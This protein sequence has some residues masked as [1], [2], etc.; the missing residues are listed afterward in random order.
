M[1]NDASKSIDK[2]VTEIKLQQTLHGLMY[3]L[4]YPSILGAGIVVVLQ[5]A[6]EHSAAVFVGLTA[7]AFFSLSFASAIGR[8]NEYNILAFVVDVVEVLVM[9]ACF[10]FLKLIEGPPWLPPS[11][12]LA[13]LVLIGVLFLQLGWRWAMHFKVWGYADLKIALVLCLVLG[14]YLGNS[15]EN[16]HGFIT[17]A[18][19]ILAGLYVANHPYKQDVPMLFVRRHKKTS[20]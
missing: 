3:G 6:T 14:A 7:M 17:M 11:V 5:H 4:Y 15:S 16:V 10:A 12:T 20:G 1:A 2:T 13:Y 9:F 8:D 19:V 18:F